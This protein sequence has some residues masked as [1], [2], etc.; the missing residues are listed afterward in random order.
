MKKHLRIQK[1]LLCLCITLFLPYVPLAQ[2]LNSGALWLGFPYKFYTIYAQ[3]NFSVHFSLGAFLGNLFIIY[4]ICTLIL[5]MIDK[6]KI[7]IKKEDSR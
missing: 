4:L 5:A 7:A 1:F 2:K 6:I 3:N